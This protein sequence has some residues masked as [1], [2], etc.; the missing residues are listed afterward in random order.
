LAARAVRAALEIDSAFVGRRPG[1]H[2][3]LAVAR[4]HGAAG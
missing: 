4:R 1:Y 2:G 3:L